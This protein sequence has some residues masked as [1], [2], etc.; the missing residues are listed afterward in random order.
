MIAPKPTPLAEVEAVKNV[1]SA[2]KSA[3]LLAP[4]PNQ[5]VPVVRTTA[6]VTVVVETTA[7]SEV[8]AEAEVVVRRP[9]IVNRQ[10]SYESR[11]TWLGL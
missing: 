3:T 4:A 5:R 1:T 6:A 10:S 9:G 11:F 7:L 8:E 2:G